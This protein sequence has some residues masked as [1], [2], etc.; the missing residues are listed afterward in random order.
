LLEREGRHWEVL[1]SRRELQVLH[2][3]LYALYM[4]TR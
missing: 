4:Q 2:S 3:G 1:E